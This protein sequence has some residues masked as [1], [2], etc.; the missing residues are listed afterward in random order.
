MTNIRVHPSSHI[1]QPLIIAWIALN[2]AGFYLIGTWPALSA[3][4]VDLNTETVDL[5]LDQA[6]AFSLRELDYIE[7]HYECSVARAAL[8]D[9]LAQIEARL[10]IHPTAPENAGP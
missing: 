4:E 1:F 9:R 7:H 8:A 5:L 3:V 6:S 10:A 2:I